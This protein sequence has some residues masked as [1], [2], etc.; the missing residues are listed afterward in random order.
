[1]PKSSY[2]ENSITYT[3]ENSFFNLSNVDIKPKVDYNFQFA[4]R[5]IHTSPKNRCEF[6]TSQGFL[7]HLQYCDN[8][9]LSNESNFDM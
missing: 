3:N 6:N 7:S 8:W 2:S 9:N 1:M 4:S 5:D